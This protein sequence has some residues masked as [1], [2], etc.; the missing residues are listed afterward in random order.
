MTYAPSALHRQ[1]SYLTRYKVLGGKR[2]VRS[3]LCEYSQFNLSLIIL[4]FAHLISEAKLAGVAA[5]EPVTPTKRG[6]SGGSSV[7]DTCVLHICLTV[8]KTHVSVAPPTLRN[9]REILKAFTTSRSFVNLL[10]K[11][12]YHPTTLY[13]YSS[14]TAVYLRWKLANPCRIRM[15]W[16][17]SWHD[18]PLT[19]ITDLNTR[20]QC[21]YI[22]LYINLSWR[23]TLQK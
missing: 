1:T 20:H 15:F 23:S 6:R 16:Y 7:Q 14:F 12:R 21:M 9:V 5:P 19:F 10:G 17:V 2:P 8:K 22:C 13:T 18:L 4:T 11:G 3:S